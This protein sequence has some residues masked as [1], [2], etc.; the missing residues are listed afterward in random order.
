M[1]HQWSGNGS[2]NFSH[3]A[4]R[5]VVRFQ[6]GLCSR[7]AL[8]SSIPCQEDMC[9]QNWIISKEL[10]A[11]FENGQGLL[12]TLIDCHPFPNA[13]VKNLFII[14]W[15]SVST[16]IQ[17]S[18]EHTNTGKNG[19]RWICEYYLAAFDSHEQETQFFIF[20]ASEYLISTRPVRTD[21]R[22]KFSPHT[23]CFHV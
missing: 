9:D 7:N 13:W 20:L 5:L 6:T 21:W 2:S 11:F 12:S 16:W 15:I 22:Y 18:W 3:P 10:A 8:Y 19:F 14:E 17:V 23:V 4:P 1:L